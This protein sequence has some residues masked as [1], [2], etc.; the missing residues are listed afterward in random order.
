M[1]AV[2]SF[3]IYFWF[4]CELHIT[5][6]HVENSSMPHIFSIMEQEG[7]LRSTICVSTIYTIL[8]LASLRN[9]GGGGDLRQIPTFR[10]EG[11]VTLICPHRHVP[12]I[13][14]QCAVTR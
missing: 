3:P 10:P 13:L 9:V 8:A 11:M 7:D 6:E 5:P 2:P 4:S 14:V 12:S 1:P